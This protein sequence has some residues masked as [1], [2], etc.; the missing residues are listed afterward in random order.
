MSYRQT[1]ALGSL[2]QPECF[3]TFR[4]RKTRASNFNDTLYESEITTAHLRL[5]SHFFTDVVFSFTQ[6]IT[7]CKDAGYLVTWMEGLRR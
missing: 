7:T 1:L 3:A 6:A 5:K 4:L 2:R